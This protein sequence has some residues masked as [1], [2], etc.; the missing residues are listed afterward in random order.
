MLISSMPKRG[1]FG[2]FFYV[3]SKLDF[4]SILEGFSSIKSKSCFFKMAKEFLTL[5]DKRFLQKRVILAILAL[6]GGQIG[7]SCF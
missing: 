4:L 7:N 2:R 6:F 1:I 3:K 5:T